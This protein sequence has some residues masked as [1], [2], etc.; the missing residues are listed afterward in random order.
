MIPIFDSLAHP[1]LTGKWLNRNIDSSFETLASSIKKAGYSGAC[2]IGLDGIENYSHKQFLGEC[3]KYDFLFPVAG[4]NPNITTPIENEIKNISGLG[5][6][7]IKIHP[8]Y[9]GLTNYIEQLEELF[10]KAAT[11]NLVVFYCTYMHCKLIQFPA[12]D[13]FYS[14]VN[15]LKKTPDLKVVL[16]HGGDVNLLRYMELVRFNENL[17][18]DLSLTMMKYKGSSLD[19][20]IRYLFTNFDRRICIG[21][22][23]PEYSHFD[24]R[25]RFEYFSQE[26][27]IDK[28]ENI[29]FLNL[30]N[31]LGI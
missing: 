23:H 17:L 5:Y 10:Q 2:A 8:R 21:T 27:A 15:L 29:A 28:L 6:T 9:S 11:E 20:D 3:R 26:V 16:V 25:K 24:I 30:T 22:D 7:A 19:L 12:Y 18:L 31:F 1:T 14:L 4:I 13:P